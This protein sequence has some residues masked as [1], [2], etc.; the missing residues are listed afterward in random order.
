MSKHSALVY[1]GNYPFPAFHQNNLLWKR[2]SAREYSLDYFIQCAILPCSLTYDRYRS[3]I[4]RN[5][6][7]AE[8]RPLPGS[9]NLIDR[10][11]TRSTHVGFLPCVDSGNSSIKPDL[12]SR[13]SCPRLRSRRRRRIERALRLRAHRNATIIRS[14]VN[15]VSSNPD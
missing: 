14:R 7:E 6:A 12:F 3:S 11:K 4:I 10:G 1:D 8:M 9:S 15:S 5:P 2:Q 13:N